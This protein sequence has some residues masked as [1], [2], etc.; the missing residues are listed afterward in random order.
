MKKN[1][2][3]ACFFREAIGRAGFL[4]LAWAAAAALYSLALAGA[5]AL[6]FAFPDNDTLTPGKPLSIGYKAEAAGTLALV[7][8]MRDGNAEETVLEAEVAA[9][10]GSVAWDGM[11]D[12]VP[13]APGNWIIQLTLVDGEGA[14]SQPK[15]VEVTVA[16]IGA[17]QVWGI[18]QAEASG[19]PQQREEEEPAETPEPARRQSVDRASLEPGEDRQ[20]STFP[21]PHELCSWSLDIDRINIYDPVDQA[22]IWEVLMQPVT[23]LDVKAKDHVYPLVSPDA[24]PKNIDNLTGQLHGRTAAVHVLETLDNGW[25]LIEAFSTDGYGSPDDEKF[26]ALD[27]KLIH[28]YVRSNLLKTIAPYKKIGL[29]IDKYTQRM[30]VFREGELFTTLLVSTG[31]PTASQPWNETP[32]GE[33]LVD[34]WVGEFPSDDILCDLALR[35]NGGCLI[36]EVPHKMKADGTRVYE[37]FESYLGQKASHGCVRTQRMRNNDGVNMGWLW[38]NLKRNT[39]ALIWDDLGRAVIP[40]PD[41]ALTM[42]YNP[43]GGKSYH[44]EQ[45]CKA[46]RDRFLPLTALPY[47]ALYEEPTNALVP[48]YGCVPFFKMQDP[49]AAIPDD[50]IGPDTYE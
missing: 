34:S 18:D 2:Q 16:D 19:D 24:D 7:A 5:P 37:P 50:V 21:D 48:C 39:K 17:A 1:P 23:V 36:H 35:I 26:H 22:K 49:N 15:S 46:V 29:V 12:G 27:N 44:S 41:E 42:Y 33:Y 43:N 10:S 25:S 3:S 28:G 47:E 13:A 11:L 30:Y 8:C 6:S 40:V 31:I 20:L 4:L 45:R 32:S 14:R 38:K 9:G